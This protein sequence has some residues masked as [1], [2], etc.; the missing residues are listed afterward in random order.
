MPVLK[1]STIVVPRGSALELRPL[2]I[3]VQVLPLNICPQPSSAAA[4]K[5]WLYSQ[6]LPKT[7]A[8]DS[9]K[10]QS[11]ADAAQVPEAKQ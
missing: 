7:E 11:P 8:A 6:P 3:M 1:A 5:T 2:A 10:M 4:L 9:N